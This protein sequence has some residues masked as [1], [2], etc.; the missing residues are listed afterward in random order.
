MMTRGLL[1]AVLASCCVG[2]TAFGGITM[3]AGSG[4]RLVLGIFRLAVRAEA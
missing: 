3:R 1:V 2:Q 4:A